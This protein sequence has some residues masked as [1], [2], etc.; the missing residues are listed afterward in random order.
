MATAPFIITEDRYGK[1]PA[2]FFAWT[3]DIT[4]AAASIRSEGIRRL[5]QDQLKQADNQVVRFT[6]LPLDRTHDNLTLWS[7][8]VKRSPVKTSYGVFTTADL[9][10]IHAAIAI[11]GQILAGVQGVT[12]DERRAA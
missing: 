12:I 1:G 2:D 9:P 8:F 10:S 11:L 4:Q 3:A 7:V 6:T 5:V